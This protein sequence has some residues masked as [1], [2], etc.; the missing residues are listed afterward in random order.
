M[1]QLLTRSSGYPGHKLNRRIGQYRR[2]AAAAAAA[3]CGVVP[4][5]NS[6]TTCRAERVRVQRHVVTS[7]LSTRFPE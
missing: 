5:E 7:E 1:E 3:V 6:R 2:Q 4:A